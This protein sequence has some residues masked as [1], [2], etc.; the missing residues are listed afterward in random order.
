[1]S[2]TYLLPSKLTE[3]ESGQSL[4]QDTVMLSSCL[5]LNLHE[6][7]LLHHTQNQTGKRGGELMQRLG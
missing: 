5:G 4:S 3:S 2:L 6:L 1:M 7:G